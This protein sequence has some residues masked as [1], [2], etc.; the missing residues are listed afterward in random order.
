MI[1]EEPKGYQ[2]FASTLSN[3]LLLSR[4]NSWCCIRLG[5][6]WNIIN[7]VTQEV[8]RCNQQSEQ[9]LQQGFFAMLFSSS[10]ASDYIYF[11]SN[12]E[13]SQKKHFT[14]TLTWK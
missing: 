8:L 13:K 2:V 11:V 6:S 14:N 7:T 4:F 3:N 1:L 5:K 12:S 9:K 10:N